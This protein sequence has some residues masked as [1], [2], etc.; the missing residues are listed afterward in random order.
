[1]DQSELGKTEVD[2]DTLSSSAELS[3]METAPQVAGVPAAVEET[4]QAPSATADDGAHTDDVAVATTAPTDDA[5]T[6]AS[7][8]GATET[9]N[10]LRRGELLTGIITR[11][12]PNEVFVDLGEGREGVLKSSELEKSPALLKELE[13]GKPV[14]VYVV[15]PRGQN[16]MAVL[17]ISLAL[18]ELD[19]QEALQYQDSKEVYAARINGYNKGGLIVRFGRLRGFVPQSQVGEGRLREIVGETP[20]ERYGRQ[21]GKSINVKVMEVDRPRN[22]L[23]LS[24]RAATREARQKAKEAL[25]GELQVNDVREG[26]V[27]SMENFGAFI[28]IGGAEGLV[29]VTEISYDHL[30]HPRQVLQVGQT[31]RVKVINIDPQNNRIGLSMK[32]LMADPW[33]EIATRYEVG[34]LVRGTITKLAKFGAFARVEGS[35]PVEGLIHISELSEGRVEK[36]QDVVKK[37]DVL[38]LRVVKVDPI[39]RRLGLSL[40]KVLSAEFLEDDLR[41][42]F[43]HPELAEAPYPVRRRSTAGRLRDA[44]E[45]LLDEVKEEVGELVEDIKEGLVEAREKV[46]QF[47]ETV[48]ERLSGDDQAEA[49][50]TEVAEAPAAE[51]ESTQ[52]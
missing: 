27:V 28:D 35:P 26:T 37:G 11:K 21:V 38:T 39:E 44:A 6:E 5:Q 2:N 42:V 1:M 41:R 9:A 14:L 50:A 49:S 31:V 17:S 48:K 12:S 40:S 30:T 46:E 20:E 10:G 47:V 32:A 43:E 7:T 29:H 25:I 19:W 45:E 13:E 24:E 23:I 52:D 34:T 18:E 4:P 22:R 3:G 51:T 8:I 36:P 15:N 16:G 33:D